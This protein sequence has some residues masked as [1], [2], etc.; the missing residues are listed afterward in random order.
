VLTAKA[1]RALKQMRRVNARLERRVQR[2]QALVNHN[3]I[4]FYFR[5]MI[6][7]Y[8]ERYLGYNLTQLALSHFQSASKT[9]LLHEWRRVVRQRRETLQ[10]MLSH[11]RRKPQ[12]AI[13]LINFVGNLIMPKQ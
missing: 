13:V 11:M 5:L 9:R 8:R 2:M 7:K 10:R 1:F 6:K 3:V 4:A 12:S